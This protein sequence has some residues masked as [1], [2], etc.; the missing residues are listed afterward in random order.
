M[1]PSPQIYYNSKKECMESI[2]KKIDE[3]KTVAIYNNIQITGIY[4]NCL[5]D[6]TKPKA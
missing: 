6:K 3:M 2:E 1:T 5:E 4:A